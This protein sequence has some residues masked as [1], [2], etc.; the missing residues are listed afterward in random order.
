MSQSK[1]CA[2]GDE[3]RRDDGCC[4]I[5]NREKQRRWYW[6][7]HERVEKEGES[8]NWFTPKYIFDAMNVIFFM[9]VAAPREG[10]R[11]TPVH[12]LAFQR[13]AYQRS[14]SGFLS[15]MN[16]PYGKRGDK[17]SKA[18]TTEI[19]RPRQRR[20]VGSRSDFRPVGSQQEAATRS[21]AV[22]FLSPKVKFEKP[23]GSIGDKPSGTVRR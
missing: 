5:C 6:R 23:D 21:D 15:F 19:P 20:D 12:R 8:D 1:K 9:D 2:H 11:Y 13:T 7:H 14:G 3:D 10:P 17:K 4:R 22:L 18:W 16:P